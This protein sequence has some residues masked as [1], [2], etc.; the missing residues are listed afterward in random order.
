MVLIFY[1]HP[2]LAYKVFKVLAV[3]Q[4]TLLLGFLYEG[5]F[6][7]IPVRCSSSILAAST[8]PVKPE[9]IAHRDPHVSIIWRAPSN[10][11]SLD[12]M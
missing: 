9:Y 7:S 4:S 10:R 1:S 6:D 12:Y 3:K 8:K 5:I 2:A 11:E